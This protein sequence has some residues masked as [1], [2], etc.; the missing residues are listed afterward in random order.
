MS[1]IAC[2]LIDFYKVD[3]ITA[4][5]FINI[6]DNNLRD[7]IVITDSTTYFDTKNIKIVEF[8]RNSTSGLRE[9]IEEAIK[10]GAEKIVLF[11]NYNLNNALW[12]VPYLNLD[13]VVIEKKRYKLDIINKIVDLFSVYPIKKLAYKNIIVDANSALELLSNDIYTAMGR[14]KEKLEIIKEGDI[15]D[16]LKEVVEKLTDLSFWKYIGI[17]LLSYFSNI[18]AFVA[19]I[20]FLPA[21]FAAILAS[22]AGALINFF[23][24]SSINFKLENKYK[25]LLKYN[26]LAFISITSQVLQVLSEQKVG[27]PVV[28]F[29][30]INLILTLL[31]SSLFFKFIWSRKGNK[32]SF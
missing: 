23:L 7:C 31:V 16:S 11:E 25:G 14:I 22:E 2:L 24:N 26:S 20:V 6:L 4:R 21:V 12:F 15:K 19:S 32:L 8:P 28:L 18:G 30:P 10:E 9:A 29:Y 5:G 27:L 13:G 1:K 17:S 3:Y